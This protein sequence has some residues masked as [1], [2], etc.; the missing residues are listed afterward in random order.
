MRWFFTSMLFAAVYFLVLSVPVG[1]QLPTGSIAGQV[2]D[3]HGAVIPGAKV[4]IEAFR[5]GGGLEPIKVTI[6]DEEG[7]FKFAGLQPGRFRL[8]V[9]VS[10]FAREV[11]KTLELIREQPQIENIVISLA[12]CSDEKEASISQPLSDSDGAEL[13]R[14][15]IAKHVGSGR[16][17]RQLGAKP[18]FLPKNFELAWLTEEQRSSIS[19][20]PRSEIQAITELAGSQTFYSVTEAE[21]NGKCVAISLLTHVSIKGQIE[22]ANMAGGEDVYEFREVSGQWIPLLLYSLIS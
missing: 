4:K 18:M 14:G 8:L 5:P 22:D 7:R 1:A 19:V 13:L 17:N 20:K 6:S 21:Q 3:A 10:F 9:K 12:A 11:S 15:L 16:R 2:M